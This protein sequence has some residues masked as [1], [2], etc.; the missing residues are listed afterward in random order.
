MEDLSN[1]G[2]FLHPFL[3][4]VQYMA[5]KSQ[6]LIEFWNLEYHRLVFFEKNNQGFVDYFET[7]LGL[8]DAFSGNLETS[9]LKLFKRVNNYVLNSISA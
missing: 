9:K 8:A 1:T 2:I 4:P 3:C 5:I 7:D 6:S